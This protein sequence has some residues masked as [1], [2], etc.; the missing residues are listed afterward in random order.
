VKAPEDEPTKAKEVLLGEAIDEL[1][2]GAY[3][4]HVW[5][6]CSGFIIAEGAEV[7]MASGLVSAMTEEFRVVS[8]IGKAMLMTWTFIGFA[9]GT[10]ASGPIGDSYG[11][12]NPMVLGYC[13][14]ILTASCTTLVTSLNMLYSMRLVLGFFAGIGIPTACI[15]ISEVTPSFLRG[16]ATAALGVAYIMGELW[17]ALG[18]LMLMP[19][20]VH[21]SWR[22]LMGWAMIPAV[23]LVIFGMLS[24]VSRYDTPFFLGCR[25]K[26]K[27][28]RQVLN[29]AAEMNDKAHLQLSED[30]TVICQVPAKIS[31][32][33]VLSTMLSPALF[34]KV[35]IM[36]FMMFAKDFAFYGS[37]VFWPQMW[38][39]VEGLGE[40]NP[41]QELV[42]TATIGIP[43]VL[44]A[45]YL[46]NCLPRRAGVFSC[47]CACGACSLYLRGLEA[48]KTSAFLGVLCYK[49][50]FPTWQMTTM[51]LPSE[52]F[53]TQIRGWTFS[54]AASFGRIATI[55]SPLA[56]EL[57]TD[58][59]TGMLAFLALG[60]AFSV[61]MLPETKDCELSEDIAN[62]NPL[63]S[64]SSRRSID[65]QT[66]GA[67]ATKV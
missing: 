5:I 27:E 64:Q 19:D 24:P 40:L 52:L 22:L 44:L 60:A 20:L 61:L 23:S 14:V 36:C 55:I 33:E 39:H 56:V 59:F 66:Y 17:A 18:L 15:A 65:A 3:Q 48:G 37:D 25:G 47:A 45:M 49:I 12:R 7:Q 4:M 30:D 6:L 29:L 67:A 2:F 34:S 8:H 13:G 26:T 1:G 16:R 9:L 43:G 54:F 28:L 31:F 53:G 42:A 41:A 35:L 51:L 58:A 62:E 63:V 21:G 38:A 46:M 50:L 11:R 57:G 32:S 10:M